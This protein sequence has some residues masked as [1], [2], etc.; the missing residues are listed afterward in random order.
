[1]VGPAEV[2]FLSETRNGVPFVYWNAVTWRYYRQRPRETYLNALNRLLEIHEADLLVLDRPVPP[3]PR[4][5]VLAAADDAYGV[6]LR[7]VR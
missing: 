1:V 3:G 6:T 7:T 4:D 5:R 2:L